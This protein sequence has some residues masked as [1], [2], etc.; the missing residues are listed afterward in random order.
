MTKNAGKLLAILIAMR[1]RQC[2]AVRIFQW[3]TS[4]AS[5]EDTGCCHRVSA[6]AT[7]PLG[8]HGQQIFEN[9]KHYQKPTFG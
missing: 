2:D 6:C 3:C 4:H 7:L 1:M 8:R 5:L 9:T